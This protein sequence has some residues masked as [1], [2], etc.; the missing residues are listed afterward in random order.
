MEF[1]KK[2]SGLGHQVKGFLEKLNKRHLRE[3]P[4]SFSGIFP[5]EISEN[6]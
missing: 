4:E 3:I 5:Q 1:P 2:F 6:F